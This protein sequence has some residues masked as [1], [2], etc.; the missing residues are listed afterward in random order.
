MTKEDR[1]TCISYNNAQDTATILTYNIKMKNHLAKL[2]EEHPD[3]VTLTGSGKD[4]SMLYSLPKEWVNIRPPRRLTEEQ[5]EAARK[6]ARRMYEIKQ[7][8]QGG[9]Q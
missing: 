9:S 1:K 2:A 8:K 6:N 7:S 5:R 3:E 4:G